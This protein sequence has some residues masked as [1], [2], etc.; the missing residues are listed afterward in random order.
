MANRV[1]S[2]GEAAGTPSVMP[3]L[4]VIP[5][6]RVTG[7][8]VS[9]SGL[10]VTAREMLAVRLVAPKLAAITAPWAVVI[11][12][13][14]TVNDAEAEFAGMVS[15]PGTGNKD[16]RLLVRDTVTGDGSVFE[17]VTVQVVLALEARLDAAHCRPERV[18][19][20]TNEMLA[21]ADVPLNV[22]V[23]VA[24]WS[25]ASG[26]VLTVKVEELD[27]GATCAAE[28]TFNAD[29]ALSESVT[30]VSLVADFDSLTVQVVLAFEGRLAAP[31]CRLE[32]VMGA[33]SE[34]VTGWDEPFS[35]AVTVADWSDATV[36]V[37]AVKVA[38]VALAATLTEGGTVKTDGALL[39][40]VTAVLLVTDFV[41]VT[42]QVVL[43]LEARVVAVH[44]RVEMAGRVVNESVTDW[45]EPFSEAV[46]V[47]TGRPATRR[48][49]R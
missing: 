49:W 11:V 30:I 4:P 36:P 32:T 5:G 19:G 13:A 7:V 46:M 47:A 26:P 8:Q 17:R 24:D 40:I 44:C 12:A 14:D 20:A 25:A 10:G 41:R 38:E 39:V 9:D 33:V 1:T 15:V 27:V 34:K 16:G 18:A 37:L 29:G 23:T 35:A 2:V 22:A 6:A 48:Y 28:G 45:D 43:A 31:H 21:A 42:V 3:Q